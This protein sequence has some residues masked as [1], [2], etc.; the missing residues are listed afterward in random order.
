[1]YDHSIKD[2]DDFWEEQANR[3]S[4]YEKWGSVSNND[5][6]K[7]QIKWF[8]DG[9]LNASYNCLDRHIETGHGKQT[10]IIW[11]GNEPGEDKSFSYSELLTEVCKFANVLKLCGVTKGDRVCIYMQMIPQLAIAMLACTRI[12]AVHSIVFGAFSSNSLYCKSIDSS[13]YSNA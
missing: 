9:K 10:A 5:F 3:L 1:M 2:P 12:G 13:L 6:T 11:E 7:A 4:W 8:Q